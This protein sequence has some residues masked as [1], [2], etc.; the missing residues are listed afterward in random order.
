MCR[1]GRKSFYPRRVQTFRCEERTFAPS[2]A[3]LCPVGGAPSPGRWQTCACRVTCLTEYGQTF[4]KPFTLPFFTGDR[5]FAKAS[6][7]KVGYLFYFCTQKHALGISL[8]QVGMAKCCF[9]TGKPGNAIT[10]NTALRVACDG[11]GA[12]TWLALARVNSGVCRFHG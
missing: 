11:E 3:H 9:S 7:Q 12:A 2:L 1:N 10:R 5:Y 4:N 8:L 6:R